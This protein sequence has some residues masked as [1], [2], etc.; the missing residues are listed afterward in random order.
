[1]PSKRRPQARR[2]RRPRAKTS[3]SK[4]NSIIPRVWTSRKLDR[5][6][7]RQRETYRR[8]ISIPAKVRRGASPTQAAAESGTTLETAIRW[9]PYDF[10]QSPKSRRWVV[11]KSDRH[12]RVMKDIGDDGMKAVRVY[13]S[14]EASQ[15]SL[16]LHDVRKALIRNDPK[17]LGRW[18]G[19]RIG[20]RPLIT[21]FRKLT[22]LADSGALQ[23]E[24]LYSDFGGGAQ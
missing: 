7:P 10:S 4:S 20:G 6:T 12:V 24:D 17:L 15:Q 19:K 3:K 2:A 16:F 9:L 1:M 13:G 18:H 11:S 22:A 8:V 21:S 14:R 5:L 23:F